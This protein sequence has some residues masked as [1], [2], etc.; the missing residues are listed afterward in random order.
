MQLYKFAFTKIYALIKLSG[1]SNSNTGAITFSIIMA[2]V[3]INLLAICN[4]AQMLLHTN[5][6]IGYVDFV[7]LMLLFAI[8]YKY[9]LHT[10]TW[11]APAGNKTDSKTDNSAIGYLAVLLYMVL[12]AWVLIATR[13]FLAGI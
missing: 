3:Y 11:D 2:T 6:F 13:H 10:L 1:A 5:K 4:A 12:S 9:S 7:C 8:D